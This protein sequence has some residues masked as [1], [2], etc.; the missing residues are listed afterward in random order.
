MGANRTD[1]WQ[2]LSFASEALRGNPLGDPHERPLWVWVPED[3]VAALPVGLRD[4]G[5]AGMADAWFNV[6]PWSQSFP[7][8][9]TE[10]AP[11][12]VVVLVDAFTAVGGSQFLDS[13]GD[14]QLPHLPLRRDR[15]VRRRA[16]PDAAGRA[17]PRHPGQ[18]VGRLRRDDH[19]AAPPRPVRRA[20]DACR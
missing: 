1:R 9:V 8:A 4:P 19:A 17:A 7:D 16:L 20:R 13:P 10:L 2:R 18:V 5:N 6:E 12:A 14:R 15:P 11:D 3:D